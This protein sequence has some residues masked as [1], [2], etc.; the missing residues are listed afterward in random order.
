MNAL[1][2]C[3][4]S[5]PVEPGFCASW[6]PFSSSSRLSGALTAACHRCVGPLGPVCSSW[7]AQVGRLGCRDLEA[8]DPAVGVP[9][10]GDVAVAP[11]LLGDPLVDDEL[12]VLRRLAAEEVEL[13]TRTPGAAHRR[14]HDHVLL[15]PP[16][17]EL[18][19]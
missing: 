17:G 4:T 15:V 12:A 11:R 18:A 16:V 9:D 1:R 13:A 8:G 7:G 14:V 19:A 2:S 6:L 5:G 3:H 10:D